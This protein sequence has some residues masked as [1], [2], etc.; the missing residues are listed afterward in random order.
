MGIEGRPIIGMEEGDERFEE[1]RVVEQAVHLLQS[2][3]E[4]QKLGREDCLPQRLLGVYFGAQQRWLQS[5]RKG[6]GAIVASFGPEREHPPNTNAL[7][8]GDFH[9]DFGEW[10][11]GT[12][13][14][15]SRRTVRDSL[16]SYGS[17]RPASGERDE[18]PVGEERGLTLLTCRPAIAHALAG[19]RRSRLN[20]LHGPSDD[21]LVDAPMRGRTTRSGRRPRSS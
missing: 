13:P 6:T 3:W 12:S 15:R 14:S 2:W 4:A 7:V 1:H 10:R 21:V 19:L 20:L 8:T 16:P 5:L 11:E 9:I 18:L 17:H